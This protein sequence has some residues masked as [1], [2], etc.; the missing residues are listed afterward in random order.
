MGG[1]GIGGGFIFI[2]G[3]EVGI[4]GGEVLE[5][6]DICIKGIRG[7]MGG[8]GLLLWYIGGVI[9]W[10]FCRGVNFWCICVD[11]VVIWCCNWWRCWNCEGVWLYCGIGWSIGCIICIDRLGY[12][13]GGLFGILEFVEGVEVVEWID[14]GDWF[15]VRE[16]FGEFDLGVE[17]GVSEAG[18]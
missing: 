16:E 15:V 2:F 14:M 6:F 9:V 3:L 10:G 7:G 1:G 8:W 4:G 13:G 18:L 11:I 17:V 5:F 12:G